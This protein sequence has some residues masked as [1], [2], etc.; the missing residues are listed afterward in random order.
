MP[1]ENES[2]KPLRDRHDAP[3]KRSAGWG[4][5]VVY[6]CGEECA[7]SC[8]C[9]IPVDNDDGICMDCGCWITNRNNE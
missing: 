4:T 9:R 2:A 8:T 7:D 1:A 5:P 3:Y 6:D